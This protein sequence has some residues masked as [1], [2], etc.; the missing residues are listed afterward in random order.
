MFNCMGD[1]RIAQSRIIAHGLIDA[2]FRS[3][4]AGWF[5]NRPYKDGLPGG[6]DT[7]AISA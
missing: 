5:L 6:R 3:E 7:S 1:S 2:N 4:T